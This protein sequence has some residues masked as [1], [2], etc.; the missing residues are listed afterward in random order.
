MNRKIAVTVALLGW[1]TVV[2]VNS[3][4]FTSTPGIRPPSQSA[5]QN[6]PT[7]ASQSTNHPAVKELLAGM[8]ERKRALD[9]G[10]GTRNHGRTGKPAL[11]STP[12]VANGRIPTPVWGRCTSR[13]GIGRKP[14]SITGLR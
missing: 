6:L 3:A 10:G 14:R 2:P 11:G 1:L 4:D 9:M 8:A 12:D 13:N 5:R 7:A